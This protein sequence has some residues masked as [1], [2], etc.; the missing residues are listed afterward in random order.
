MKIKLLLATSF[1]ALSVNIS[2]ADVPVPAAELTKIISGKTVSIGNQSAVYSANGTY[3]FAGGFPGKWRV[4]AGRICVDFNDGRAR[5]DRIVR[6]NGQ[7]YMI[8]EQNGFRSNFRP[9]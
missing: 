2:L 8:T 1:L 6:D 3:T 4:S 7:L 5:C 9:Q